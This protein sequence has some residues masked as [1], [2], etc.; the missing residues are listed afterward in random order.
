MTRSRLNALLLSGAANPPHRRPPTSTADSFPSHPRSNGTSR[1]DDSDTTAHSVRLSAVGAQRQFSFCWTPHAYPTRNTALLFVDP[2]ND[3]LSEGG[4]IWPRVQAVA[5]GS[6][7]LDNLRTITTAVR[8]AGI[9]VF[10]APHRRW[11]PGDYEDWAY[12]NPTQ[13][14][15][16]GRHSF[17]RGE[18]GGEWHPDF[19]PRPGDGVDC[20]CSAEAPRHGGKPRTVRDRRKPLSRRPER[21][22][23]RG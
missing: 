1:Q 22:R 14:D 20:V 16:M 17:A 10:I 8:A 6:G 23:R 2:Y 19:A 13:R 7:L 5:E 3:F 12:P 15:I 4:R 11:E 18:W 21:S 9:R